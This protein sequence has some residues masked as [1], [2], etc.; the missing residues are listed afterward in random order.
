MADNF[1]PLNELP[2]SLVQQ[3][4]ESFDKAQEPLQSP[5]K[6]SLQSPPKR[7]PRIRPDSLPKTNLTRS[8]SINNGIRGSFIFLAVII[9]ILAYLNWDS[10]PPLQERTVPNKPHNLAVKS[11]GAR[12]LDGYTTPPVASSPAWL[13]SFWWQYSDRYRLDPECVIRPTSAECWPLTATSSI[14]IELAKSAHISQIQVDIRQATGFQDLHVYKVS[15]DGDIK[16]M[17][18]SRNTIVRFSHSIEA[19]QLVI[20]VRF[21]KNSRPGCLNSVIVEGN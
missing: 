17:G 4:N 10:N 18:S 9:F 13:P 5:P 7:S 1:V 15:H 3:L 14:G 11:E 16:S 21:A 20:R 8:K 12:I 2:R 6:S 19:T